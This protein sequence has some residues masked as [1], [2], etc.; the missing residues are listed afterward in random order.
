[1]GT[2]LDR[3]GVLVTQHQPR[4]LVSVVAHQS[5]IGG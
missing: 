4:H 3:A 5:V 2:H 1:M